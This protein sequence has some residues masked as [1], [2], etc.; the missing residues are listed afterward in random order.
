MPEISRRSVL[1][2]L[3]AGALAAG[4]TSAVQAAMSKSSNTTPAEGPDNP[5]RAENRRPGSRDWRIGA[6]GTVAADD[7]GRQIKG[8]ASAAS[9]NLGES[10]GFHVS[11][12]PAGRFTV[13]I[14]RMGDYGGLGARRLASSPSLPGA[15]KSEPVTDPANGMISCDWS[16]DWA[17][18]VPRDW[19]SGSYLAAFTSDTGHRS[20][21]PFVVRDD[22][23][24]ADFL[25]VLPFATYQAYNQWPLDGKVGKSL[26]YGYGHDGNPNAAGSEAGSART[27]VHGAPIAYGTRAKK[28]S[29]SR[30]YSGVGLPQRADLDYEFLQWA[31]RSGYDVSY[32]TSVDLHEGRV[33]ASQYSALVFSGHDEYWSR[34]MRDTVTAAMDDGTHLAFI[35]ANNVYWHV[36][37][38]PDP[39]GHGAP[40]MACWKSDPDPETDASGPTCLWRTVSS[41]GAQAEQSLIGVQYNGI[42]KSEVP[43]SVSTP[44]HWFWAGTGV[45]DQELIPGIVGGEADG[46]DS[47]APRPDSTEHTMLS[48]SHYMA[49]GGSNWPRIQHTSLYETARGAVVFDA[50][51]FN[52]SFGLNRPGYVDARIQ[53]A[54]QNL[55]NRLRQRAA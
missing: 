23:R 26:Y 13:D 5:I 41:N 40:V 43:L 21:A 52:W 42:P 50:A 1:A 55:F 35:A 3:G 7:L 39:Q 15:V 24:R 25:V 11:T 45:K 28:V 51:T 36:R 30:P 27:D 19:T 14:Y 53:K 22:A 48:A 18:E 29:F 54:T 20:F 2:V 10:I 8:Y 31:E 17:L 12:E 38:E 34:T 32:S 44:D 6:G 37:F 49:L 46:F 9:V 16:A 4:T 33:E 47:G